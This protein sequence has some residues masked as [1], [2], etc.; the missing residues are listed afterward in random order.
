MI[1]SLQ[2]NMNIMQQFQHIVI[3]SFKKKQENYAA[4][5]LSR[6][7]LIQ[8]ISFPFP[9]SEAL[10]MDIGIKYTSLPLDWKDI[11]AL[12]MGV[13]HTLCK[14]KYN[15]KQILMNEFIRSGRWYPVTRQ[16]I[17]YNIHYLPF[18]LVAI[19]TSVHRSIPGPSFYLRDILCV[20]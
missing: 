20:I 17:S 16:N 13:C 4:G 2:K 11:N 8:F 10:D 9:L 6:I 14:R 12:C 3:I 1:F 19:K 15:L 7:K 5:S 18:F